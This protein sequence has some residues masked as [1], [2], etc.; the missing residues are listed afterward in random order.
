MSVLWSV[1]VVWVWAGETLTYDGQY[2][3]RLS[4]VCLTSLATPKLRELVSQV[5]LH[6]DD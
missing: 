5:P 6:W 1:V 4:T 3:S 2:L